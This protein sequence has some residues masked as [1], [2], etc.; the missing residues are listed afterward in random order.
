MVFPL[1]VDSILENVP[2]LGIVLNVVFHDLS[3]PTA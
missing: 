1:I 2:G 3:F